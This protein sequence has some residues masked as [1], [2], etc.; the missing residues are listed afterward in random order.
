[1]ADDCAI[2]LHDVASPDVAA[3]LYVLEGAGFNI[4]LFQ[5]MQIMAIAW[6]GRAV[7]VAPCLRRRAMLNQASEATGGGAVRGWVIPTI[8]LDTIEFP[9]VLVTT[10]AASAAVHVIHRRD[11]GA[12]WG[13]SVVFVLMR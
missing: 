3:A 6:R 2:L 13:Q 7:P 9:E 10:A 4:R 11:Q 8:D 12:A 1:M 5:T